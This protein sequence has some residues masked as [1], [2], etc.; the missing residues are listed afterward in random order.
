MG[1]NAVGLTPMGTPDFTRGHFAKRS[2]EKDS[3]R[4]PSL[5]L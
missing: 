5:T 1:L 4:T 3:G 2:A